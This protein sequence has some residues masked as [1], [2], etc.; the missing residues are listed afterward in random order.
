M[1]SDKL[2]QA[3]INPEK[4]YHLKMDIR[5]IIRVI[6]SDRDHSEMVE[7]EL[8]ELDAEHPIYHLI[9]SLDTWESS[10][11]QEFESGINAALI[12]LDDL[13]ELALEEE[14]NSV[15]S[16]SLLKSVE[17]REELGGFDPTDP[18]D[19]VLDFL[20]THFHGE[21]DVHLGQLGTHVRKML[22]HLDEMDEDV[23]NSLLDIIEDRA[24]HLKSDK[25]YMSERD[26]I[27]YQI[28]IK[29]HLGEEVSNEQERLIE[30]YKDEFEQKNSANSM[31]KADI[32][33]RGVAKCQEFLSDEKENEW[34]LK[35]R[36]LNKQAAEEMPVRKRE[37]DV[38]E[39]VSRIIDQFKQVREDNTSW[40]AL[41][42]LLY[43]PIGQGDFQASTENMGETP[44][45]NMLPKSV[46]SVEGDS[47]GFE[48]GM[49][50]EG[51]RAPAGYTDE[52]N[53]ANHTLAVALQRLIDDNL[54]SESDFYMVLT[55]IPGVS[56]Q[57]EAFLTDALINFFEERYAESI[58]LAIPRLESVTANVYEEMGKSVTKNQGQVYHQKGLGGLFGL[59]EED[60]STNFGKYLQY[61]Y[62]DTAGQNIRNRVAH[63]QIQYSST[64][65]KLAAT[66]LFDIFRVGARIIN[67]YS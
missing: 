36:E 14:W 64:N 50:Q 39:D 56:I 24:Q 6:E 13:Y 61:R 45:A 9:E 67:E 44:G 15:A 58:H 19:E 11:H 12:A 5:R 66:T 54:L 51:E 60:I 23:I 30:T 35:I 62:T 34:R 49:T 65:F 29:S 31:I 55:L 47:V 25:Q 7:N 63:G 40:Q 37:V 52:L 57:D 8:E 26:Y 4:D 2:E 41:A 32:L 53:M 27:D 22:E 43:A 46:L 38:G 59:I 10:D 33:E 18:F 16:Y 42:N 3:K 48:P 17:Y 21:S 28:T 1:I 20:N